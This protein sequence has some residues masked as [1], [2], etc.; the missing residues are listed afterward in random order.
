MRGL[1]IAGSRGVAI[2]EGSV[3]EKEKK[4]RREEGCDME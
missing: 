4:E 3:G 2:V 1:W